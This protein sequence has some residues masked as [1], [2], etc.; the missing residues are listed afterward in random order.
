MLKNKD[1]EALL[2]EIK[3]TISVVSC[4]LQL[5]ERQHPEV[6]D[7]AFWQDTASDLS[8]L[9]NL[10]IDVSNT[11][12]CDH[13]KKSLVNISNFLQEV[14]SSCTAANN[15]NHPLIIDIDPC[16]TEGYFDAPRIQHALLRIL[17]NAFESLY[18]DGIVILRAYS[19]ENGIVFEVKD[20]GHGIAADVLPQIFQPFFGS[21]SGKSGL[22]L[23][24]SKGI[25][26]SHGGTLTLTSELAKGTTVT[27]FL[28]FK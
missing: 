26:E 27:I 13:A 1:Y 10:L 28:P 4:S 21:K 19:K 9:R 17:D 23:P 18:D 24:I 25:V 2:H 12:L 14:Q 20:N 22:G 5:I 15:S 16:L 8:G 7:Y 11:Q 3:N 6:K